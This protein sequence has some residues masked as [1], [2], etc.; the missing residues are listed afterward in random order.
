MTDD[1]GNPCSSASSAA[2]AAAERALWRMMSFY[3]IPLADLDTAMQADPGWVLPH[4]MKAGY[5]LSLTE[6]RLLPEVATQLVQARAL[7][8]HATRREREHLRAVQ[9]LLEGRW[10]AARRCWGG[11]LVEYPRDALALQW[12][13]LWDLHG[14]DAAGLRDHPAGALPEWDPADPLY[15]HVLALLA[16]GLGENHE[17]AQAEEAGRRA[18]AIDPR[19]PWAVHAVAHV[20]DAQGR[21]EEGLAWLR[22]HQAAWADGN[23]F[24]VHLW[25]HK[26]LF[27]LESLDIEGVL[28][29]VD[30]H[31]GPDALAIAPQRVDAASLLWRLHLLGVDVRS[32]AAA[33]VDGWGWHPSDAGHSAFVDFHRVLA[34]TAAGE[35]PRAESWLARCAEHTLRA[36]DARRDNHAVARE[37][38]LPL[39]RGVL[40]LAHG[41]ADAAAD[42]IERVRPAANRIGGSRT[43]RDAIELTLL[44]AAS[45]GNRRALGRALVNR[46]SLGRPAT[47]LSRHW[48]DSVGASQ[49][50]EGGGWA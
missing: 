19:A 30:T 29:L 28:R 16:F 25:W 37:V 9:L 6:A 43:Q 49:R 42:A 20:M 12:L 8:R 50:G 36:E 31:L 22:S 21:H 46:R 18:L 32:P 26:S 45:Q 7:A 24:A 48:A 2:L 34:L 11:L 1:R 13:Q 33:L 38:G 47:P 23:G 41:D 17:L 4:V 5:L 39:M 14:G 44:A 27:R 10:H 40:A 3:D 15:P 35:L